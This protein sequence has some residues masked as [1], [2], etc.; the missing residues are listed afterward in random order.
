MDDL[1]IRPAEA[2]DR[3][4]LVAF[5]RAMAKETEAVDLAVEV[6]S[7]GVA[8][9]M[10]RPQYGFYLVAETQGE[11]VG[12][13]MV[14]YEWSDWR[15]GLFW[16][17]QSVYVTPA[18]RGKGIYPRLYAEVKRRAA[19]QGEVC[20]FRLYVERDNQRAQRTYR[21]LGMTETRYRVFEELLN[22]RSELAP[23]RGGA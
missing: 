3:E 1:I 21:S 6:V 22:R 2:R 16:W 20:G 8:A 17:I 12:G 5:N 18:H 10:K 11:A 7:A 23:D 4:A 19:E 13:L 15:N 9:L 14:T